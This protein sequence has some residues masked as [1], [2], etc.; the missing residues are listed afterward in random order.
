M[1]SN[2]ETVAALG[3]GTGAPGGKVGQGWAGSGQGWAGSGQGGQRSGLC[4]LCES[5]R[6]WVVGWAGARRAVATATA[7]Q[8]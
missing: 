1:H 5:L 3:D 2:T 7:G 4:C 6:V 8:H